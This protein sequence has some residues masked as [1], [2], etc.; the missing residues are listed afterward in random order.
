MFVSVVIPV[1]NKWPHLLRAIESV[2]NQTLED[3]EV[4]IVDDA[5]T[6]GSAEI[7]AAVHDPRVRAYRRSEPGLGGY[8]A[9][10]LGIERAAADWIAFLDADDEWRPDHLERMGHLAERHPEASILACGWEIAENGVSVPNP[11]YRGYSNSE[12]S[13]DCRT[14]LRVHADGMD[15]AHT[16]VVVVRKSALQ[17]IDGFP[18]PSK[19]CKRAGDGQ[20]W[21]RVMLSGATM[22]WSPHIGAV[23]HQDAVN[24]VTR[25]QIYS[26][27]ENGLITY[28]RSHLEDV[29]DRETKSLLRKYMNK[30]ILSILFQQARTESVQ[31][32]DVEEALRAF[33]WDP[34]MLFIISGFF[35]PKATRRVLNKLA[36]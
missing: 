9:R 7:I 25:K 21:L 30:R 36:P 2:L 35:A 14:Y 15:V 12:M 8:Q 20:T 26:V 27:D 18:L 31:Q 22:V 13:I 28:I 32:G 23:Y 10:N 5:S 24:M 29:A 3:F 19:H 17:C 4:I 6:D 34:R 33:C 16:N 1:Y 11:F